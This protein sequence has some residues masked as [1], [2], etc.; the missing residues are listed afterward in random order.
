MEWQSR[1]MRDDAGFMAPRGP[2]PVPAPGNRIVRQPKPIDINL[3]CIASGQRHRGV[4]LGPDC[5]LDH[6]MAKHLIEAG[7]VQGRATRVG[8]ERGGIP[9]AFETLAGSIAGSLLRGSFPLTLGGDHSIAFATL[10]GV[11]RAQPDAVILY[12]DAHGDANTPATSPT[13]HTH[14]MPV[15]AQFGLMNDSHLPEMAG[16]AGRLDPGRIAYFGIRDVDPGEQMIL[17][18]LGV[19]Q[20][21][22]A[23]VWREGSAA[24]LAS[25]L[26]RIDPSHSRPIHVSF[27]IDVVDP[28]FAPATGVPVADG[29][30]PDH[31]RQLAEDLKATGRVVSMDV[32]EVN[33]ELAPSAD[34]LAATAGIAMNFALQVLGS[35]A[36]SHQTF[37]SLL[38][39]H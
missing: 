38:R 4:A 30:H 19:A 12:V 18:R 15:A 27:D 16:V 22:S 2:A 14:G 10:E 11:L 17:D 21:T 32:V 39:D 7:W 31:V 34:G 25:L 29:L 5:L 8:P 35:G 3:A 23:D 33:P 28:G 37:T 26:G 13:G 36:A 9:A 20:A 6:G 24:V 1:I